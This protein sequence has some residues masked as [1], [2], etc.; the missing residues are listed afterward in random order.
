MIDWTEILTNSIVALVGSAG[1]W[2]F[3]NVLRL[4]KDVDA[5]FRKIRELQGGTPNASMDSSL[6][7]PQD[8][9]GA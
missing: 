4:R 5:A 2:L 8:P 3:T 1:T 9:D 7:A 6:G